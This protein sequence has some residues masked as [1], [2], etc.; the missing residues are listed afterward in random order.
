MIKTFIERAWQQG[1]LLMWLLLPL[2]LLYGFITSCRRMSYRLGIKRTVSLDVP[3]IVVGN[4]TVGGN[5]KTPVVIWLAHLLQ[6]H[7]L[8]VGIISRGYGGTATDMMVVDNNSEASICGD[9]PTLIVKQTGCLMAVGRDRVAVGRLLLAH[10]KK[11]NKPLDIIISDDGLQHYRL[12]RDMEIVVIDGLR[13]FGN[14]HLLPMGPLR[15]GLWRLKTVDLLINNG[16]TGRYNEEHMNLEPQGI[17]RVDNNDLVDNS[18][19][20][21]KDVIAMA[22]IGYPQRFFDTLKELGIDVSKQHAFEDHQAFNL[23]ALQTLTNHDEVLLMTEKDAV[24][25]Q[26]FAPSNW[27][28]LPV[29]AK[30]TLA[31]KQKILEKLKEIK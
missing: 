12:A 6:Q 9:E 31:A 24:K 23:A 3:V 30:L 21:D 18:H 22:G 11:L 28:Y 19:F 2:R 4:I 10:A 14:N 25:C 7:G 20:D 13:R 15:E 29:S 27:F 5:G 17:R 1:H 26:G 8:H 16:A